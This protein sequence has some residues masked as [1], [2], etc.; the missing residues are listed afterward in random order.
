MNSVEFLGHVV[1]AGGVAV[2]PSKVNKVLNWPEPTCLTN[3][4]AFVGLCAYY[5]RFLPNFSEMAKPL[6]DLM[7][8]GQ[9]FVW[10]EDQRT[11]MAALQ[12]KLTTAPILGYPLPEGS[13]ILGTDASNTDIGCVLSQ[14][15]CGSERVIA[16]GSKVLQQSQRNY[17]TTRRELLAIVTFVK[18]YRHYLIGAP[19]LIRTDH[20]ALIWLLRKK[21][22]EG[23]MARWV[24]L[25]QE[26]DFVVQHRPG[27][28]HGNADAL[29]RCMEGCR[30]SDH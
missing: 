25:L 27:L 3:V 10:G 12:E 17:C 6:Y 18:E 22:P 2:N 19:V 11:A 14:L 28:K 7:R 8:E 15:Q 20:A 16:Y 9:P 21:D 23:Q 30:D 1:S 24:S 13:F 26:Y 4:R 29:S 5:R